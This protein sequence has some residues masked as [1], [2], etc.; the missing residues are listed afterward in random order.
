MKS[1]RK[2]SGKNHEGLCRK[3]LQTATKINVCGP[4]TTI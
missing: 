1:I 3:P 4:S 2:T